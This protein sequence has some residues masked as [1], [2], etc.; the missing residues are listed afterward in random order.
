MWQ[1]WTYPPGSKTLL[2]KH[3][4]SLSKEMSTT[5]GWR[6]HLDL[7]FVSR[8]SFISFSSTNELFDASWPSAKRDLSEYSDIY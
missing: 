1:H 8:S 3:E 7:K 6:E 4:S 5:G 2:Q